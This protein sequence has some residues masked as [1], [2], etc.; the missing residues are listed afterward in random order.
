[1]NDLPKQMMSNDQYGM[2]K[3]QREIEISALKKLQ[4]LETFLHYLF[5]KYGFSSS[6]EILK[7]LELHLLKLFHLLLLYLKVLKDL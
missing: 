2:K 3:S 5:E 1:M 6:K 7:F 4:P